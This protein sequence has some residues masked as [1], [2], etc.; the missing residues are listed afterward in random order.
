MNQIVKYNCQALKCSVECVMVNDEPWFKGQTVATFLEY[1]N[2]NQAI[3][4]NVDDEDKIKH[5]ALVSLHPCA[6][7][8]AM[9]AGVA[10][11]FFINESGLWLA[12]TP[13]FTY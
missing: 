6:K 11:V 13:W 4:L 12:R 2:K 7:I 5:S 9:D 3:R 10:N 8:Q 1:A